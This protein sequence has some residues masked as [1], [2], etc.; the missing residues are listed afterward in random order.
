MFFSSSDLISTVNEGI[1]WSNEDEFDSGSVST[2][3]TSLVYVL[4][5]KFSTVK[6]VCR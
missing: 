3:V 1:L 5:T 6:F 4:Y 2:R